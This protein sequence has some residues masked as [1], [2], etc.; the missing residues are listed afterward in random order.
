MTIAEKAKEIT[1]RLLRGD[2]TPDTPVIFSI[3]TNDHVKVLTDVLTRVPDRH[4][5]VL[6][7]RTPNLLDTDLLTDPRVTFI[8]TG[9][10][11]EPSI[12]ALIR[13][14]YGELEPRPISYAS[15]SIGGAD[16]RIADRAAD[17]GAPIADGTS[18]PPRGDGKLLDLLRM[19]GVW[20][21]V[22]GGSISAIMLGTLARLLEEDRKD[23]GRARGRPNQRWWQ[24]RE[25]W[26]SVI[27]GTVTL[28]VARVAVP[29]AVGYYSWLGAVTRIPEYASV[30]PA[31]IAFL[32]AYL[33]SRI[34]ELVRLIKGSPS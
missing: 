22:V 25:L 16:N 21:A 2:I 32:G 20:T 15:V 29:A 19:V 10:G 1:E 8:A 27:W 14:L 34:L 24:R 4:F 23:D 18:A 6:G 17:L 9:S 26:T 3:V 28:I 7:L 30:I 13:V 33:G 31:V 12:N 5:V 11:E